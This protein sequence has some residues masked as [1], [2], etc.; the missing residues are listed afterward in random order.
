[1]FM[2]IGEDWNGTPGDEWTLRPEDG[3]GPEHGADSADQPTDSPE[4]ELVVIATLP[5][6]GDEP[7]TTEIMM[8]HVVG[9]YMRDMLV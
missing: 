4:Y 1:M 6:S 2:N 3:S 9:P 8:R 5:Y 7:R